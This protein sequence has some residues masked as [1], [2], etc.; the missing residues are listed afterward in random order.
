MPPARSIRGSASPEETDALRDEG[1]DVLSL[2]AILT[3]NLQ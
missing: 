2:P 1:I 3:R